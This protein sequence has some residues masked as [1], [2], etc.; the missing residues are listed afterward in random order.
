MTLQTMHSSERWEYYKKLSCPG[1]D[2]SEFVSYEA[3]WDR[4]MCDP[5]PENVYIVLK[6]LK[7]TENRMNDLEFLVYQIRNA[8]T[9]FRRNLS[10]V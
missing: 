5:E 9:D 7:D 1:K 6:K 3:I 10:C 8:I 4:F 2:W